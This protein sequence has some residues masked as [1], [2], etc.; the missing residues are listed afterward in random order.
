MIKFKGYEISY[1]E[2]DDY[3][4]DMKMNRYLREKELEEIAISHKDLLLEYNKNKPPIDDISLNTFQFKE[5]KE[6]K[7]DLCY[8]NLNGNI[9]Y[10]CNN[11][12]FHL[13]NNIIAKQKEEKLIKKIDELKKTT[14]YIYVLILAL[15]INFYWFY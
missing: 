9:N 8:N 1:Q 10:S 13:L 14:E 3:F 7:N 4:K 5:F 12:L 6:I 2:I 15:F 11:A